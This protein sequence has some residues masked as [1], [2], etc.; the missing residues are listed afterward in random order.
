M[1]GRHDGRVT[2]QQIEAKLGEIQ[3]QVDEGAEAA[4]TNVVRS[5]V[6]LVLVVI[7][8]AYLL[9]RRRGG[10]RSTVVEIRRV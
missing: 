8:L 7:V 6:V 1:P 10:K 9:G 2:R 4:K 3:H 5:G